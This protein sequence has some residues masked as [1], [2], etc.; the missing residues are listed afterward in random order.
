MPQLIADLGGR[1]KVHAQV[2]LADHGCLVA[3][4]LEETRELGKHHALAG[5]PIEV[6][7]GDLRL[8]VQAAVVTVSR[9]GVVLSK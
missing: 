7:S 8:A 2:P 5:E 1:R 4:M 6:G 9:V 3:S